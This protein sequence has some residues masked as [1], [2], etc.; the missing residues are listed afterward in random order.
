MSWFIH[1]VLDHP[2]ASGAGEIALKTAIVYLFL[3]VGL[4]VL[5]KRELG[6][7]SVYDLVMIIVLG[8]AVQNAMINA[9]NTLVGGFVSAG[10][11]LGLNRI[12]NVLIERSKRMEHFMV[13]EPVLLVNNGAVVR[14]NMRRE[15]VTMEQLHAA[16]REHGMTEVSEARM[17]V[18]EVDGTISVV[19]ASTQVLKTRRHYR[20]LRLP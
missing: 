4:R 2:S 6:Q 13:G 7:M 9:D 3:I 14:G 5:G 18:L 15:G 1:H 20:G 10:V 8:N 12:F 17:C 16:L 11:L 19:S